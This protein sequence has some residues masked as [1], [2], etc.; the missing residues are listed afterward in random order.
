MENPAALD[1]LLS[2]GVAKLQV[3]RQPLG[4]T[5]DE[6]KRKVIVDRLANER[7]LLRFSQR[8]LH[9]HKQVHVTLVM[10]LAVNVRTEENDTLRLEA[11]DN[12]PNRGNDPLVETLDTGRRRRGTIRRRRECVAPA[13][14]DRNALLL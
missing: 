4:C 11:L 10:R 12:L 9:H 14:T 3:P 2:K 7:S 8:R 13:A 5:D 6:I 1:N